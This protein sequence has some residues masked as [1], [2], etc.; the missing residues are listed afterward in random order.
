MLGFVP[1]EGQ[2]G[3]RTPPGGCHGGRLYLQ[4]E[5]LQEVAVVRVQGRGPSIS[6][7]GRSRTRDP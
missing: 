3:G 7:S 4:G 1:G 6:E 2:A 5:F